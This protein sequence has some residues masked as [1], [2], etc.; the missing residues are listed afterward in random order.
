[1][2]ARYLH[3]HLSRTL[4]PSS[5][6]YLLYRDRKYR[7]RQILSGFGVWGYL[8]CGPVSTCAEC[9]NG[10]G[11]AGEPSL[12]GCRELSGEYDVLFMTGL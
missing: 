5:S 12:S 10:F 1:M 6:L 7:T 8:P 4:L 3:R 2:P 11:L 9:C